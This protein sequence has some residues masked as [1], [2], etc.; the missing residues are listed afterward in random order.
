MKF[1][2][3]TRLG[4][5]SAR[6]FSLVTAF[7]VA[8]ISGTVRA[9]SLD[10]SVNEQVIMLPVITNGSKLSFQTTI[11]RPPG[12]GPFP[13][14][15]MN[16]GKDR[17][18]PAKQARDRFLALSREFVKLGYA[19]A[20]P[21]RKG[22]AAS[23]GTYRDFGCNM[24]DNSRQQADDVESAL[25]AL[26]QQ[27]WVDKDR[28]IVAGQS[29][30]GLATIA[31]GARNFPGV[32]GLLNFAGGLR[33]DGGSCDWMS[34]L[35]TAFS[36][37]GAQTTLPSLWFYGENDSYFAHPL[38]E[39]LHQAYQAAGGSSQLIAYEKFKNDAHGMVG[40]RDGVRIWMPET[41]RFLKRVGMPTEPVVQ[42]ADTPRPPATNF[43][44]VDNVAAVPALSD[45]GRAG[46]RD[47]LSKSA[48]RAFALSSSGAWSWAE[49]GDDPSDR[50][51]SSCQRN[52]ST[53]CKLYSIDQDVVW[54]AQTTRLIPPMSAK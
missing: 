51:L 53:A 1:S 5:R 35:I 2:P 36:R 39:T 7:T 10:P 40:S 45:K 54:D 49:E 28:I 34:S 50:A 18:N 30:G 23:G 33:V 13:L 27:P 20:V 44:L 6:Y 15:L 8:A 4:Y 42:I 37:Y 12:E 16:H 11:F 3:I 38:A 46:Y 47:Y 29:Y 24:T 26:V 32:R 25:K 41:E 22:F 17:G 48:P 9:D 19:V 43:A 14:L 52:S 31:F 21:M